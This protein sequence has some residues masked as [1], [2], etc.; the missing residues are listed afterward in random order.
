MLMLLYLRSK[1]GRSLPPPTTPLRQRFFLTQTTMSS[2]DDATSS[3]PE[4]KH[5]STV[6]IGSVD[7]SKVKKYNTSPVTEYSTDDDTAG[8]K[9]WNVYVKEA[10]KYDTALVESWKSDMEGVLIFAGL[11][12]AILTA[13]LIESYQALTPNSGDEMKAVL[14][15]ISAQ[16]SGIAN[17]S[18]VD[19][20]MPESFVTPTSSL[21]CN[22]LWFISLGL[23]LSSA[24]IATLVEQWAR[25]FKYKTERRSAPVV[26]AR[27]YSYFYYGLKRFDM[28]AVVDIIPL[29]LHASLV[30]FLAGL[31][32]FLVPVN[33]AVM[34]SVV[35]LL[36]ILVIAYATLTVLPLFSCQSPYQTPL[37]A[38]LW[39]AIQ[40]I[41]TIWRS[42]SAW[43]RSPQTDTKVDAS[44]SEA[45][46][47]MVDAMNDAAL[48]VEQLTDR[49]CRALAWTLGSL[50]DDDELEPFLEGIVDALATTGY[51]RSYYDDPIRHLLQSREARLL[52]RVAEFLRR[53]TLFLQAETQTRRRSITLKCLWALATIPAAANGPPSTDH[54]DLIQLESPWLRRFGFSFHITALAPLVHEHEF[55]VHAV[56]RLRILLAAMRITEMAIAVLTACFRRF[57]HEVTL[58]PVPLEIREALEDLAD[59]S[60]WKDPYLPQPSSTQPPANSI[61]LRRCIV[62]HAKMD[63][64]KINSE[65]FRDCLHALHSLYPTLIRMGHEHALEFMIH[66]A[67]QLKSPPYRFDETKTLLVGLL[68]YEAASSDIAAKYSNAFKTFMD[69]Q[70]RELA[71]YPPHVDEILAKLLGFV[72]RFQEASPDCNVSSSISLSPYLSMPCFD[73]SKSQVLLQC[74]NW[75]LCSCLTMELAA[76]PE[77]TDQILRV[78]WEVAANMGSSSHTPRSPSYPHAPSRCMLEALHK[79]PDQPET[80]SLISLVQT[81]TLNDN[82]PIPDIEEELTLSS[83]L[84]GHLAVLARFIHKASTLHSLPYKMKE[85]ISIL[86]QLDFAIPFDLSPY[87]DEWNCILASPSHGVRP[88]HGVRPPQQLN[89]ARIWKAAVEHDAPAGFQAIMVEVI[90]GCSLLNMYRWPGSCG[91]RWLNN[92]EAAKV[93]VEGIDIANRRADISATS[94]RR[95]VRIRKTLIRV[96]LA[97]ETQVDDGTA[98]AL[99]SSALANCPIC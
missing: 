76:R 18:S 95:L 32:A 50:S 41:R 81:V 8:V 83:G 29:L 75:W 24:L 12:S 40:L 4:P 61:L 47:S 19:L 51:A 65:W 86:T 68:A 26:R 52:E 88:A 20:P 49:D 35:I 3:A 90:A 56:L 64:F 67:T 44:N 98:G 1:L 45:P 63:V 54:R 70:S 97:E 38:G 72:A 73:R 85:T 5:Y 13:F 59:S 28:H 74:D 27:L 84:E 39:R 37:S 89:F 94:K 31:V 21:V 71:S 14:I 93:F 7:V 58:Q 62:W 87:A 53:S 46:D 2:P 22:L 57:S 36:G 79:I 25:D 96:V 80:I 55:L 11:F 77:S 99:F 42:V 60:L 66:V 78:M 34:I 82:L 10:E 48:E 33:K 6:E 9:I 16:L 23:S 69:Y 30:L 92:R 43:E 15:Q 17:Q 91:F